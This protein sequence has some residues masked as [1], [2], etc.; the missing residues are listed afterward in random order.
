MAATSKKTAQLIEFDLLIDFPNNL[1]ILTLFIL[2]SFD[3]RG[4]PLSSAAHWSAPETFG[5]RAKFNFDSDPATLDLM[6]SNKN[7]ENK[8]FF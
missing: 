4:K 2:N 1:F 7:S 3:V 5:P 8:F 6:V